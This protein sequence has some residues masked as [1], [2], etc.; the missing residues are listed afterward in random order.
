MILQRIDENIS[1]QQA[2]EEI[3]ISPNYLSRLFKEQTGE[4][5]SEFTIRVKMHKAA[6]LLVMPDTKVYEIS[7]YLGYKSLQYF[8]KLF[9][10]IYFCT[11]SEYRERAMGKE[12]V[13]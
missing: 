1:L 13:L 10:R 9:K 2:A 3:F 7:E 5:F 8:Y 4:N 6:E 12:Q 11:P